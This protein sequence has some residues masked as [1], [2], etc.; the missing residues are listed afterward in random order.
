M[1]HGW[2]LNEWINKEAILA[3]YKKE[4][5]AEAP[6]SRF[7]SKPPVAFMKHLKKHRKHYAP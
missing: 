6:L 4:E 2:L 3:Y 5:Y 1:A 7:P